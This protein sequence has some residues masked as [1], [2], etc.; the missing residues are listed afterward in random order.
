MFWSEGCVPNPTAWSKGDLSTGRHLTPALDRPDAA[1]RSAA[2]PPRPSLR[3]TAALS[4]GLSSHRCICPL[5]PLPGPPWPQS[6]SRA[7]LS[8][9]RVVGPLGGGVDPDFR[10]RER[11]ASPR[12]RWW[13]GTLTN[14]RFASLSA[15]APQ[16][17]GDEPG[18]PGKHAACGMER[19]NVG[20]FSGGRVPSLPR[21]SHG[22]GLPTL[23]LRH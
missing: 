22:S 6:T 17:L 8:P 10:N 21:A 1:T 3:H 18:L 12:G 5:K 13:T 16:G 23:Q 4:R 15:E 14:G 11:A 2:A 19:G 20:A 7:L 9:P